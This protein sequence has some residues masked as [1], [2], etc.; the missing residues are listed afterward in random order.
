MA[1]PDGPDQR[2]CD[3]DALLS[4]QTLY[5]CPRIR[6]GHRCRR[7]GYSDRGR[8]SGGCSQRSPCRQ[9]K[10]QREHQFRQEGC[11]CGD[12]APR[13]LCRR[14]TRQ[15][16]HCLQQSHRRDPF[17]T[18]RGSRRVRLLHHQAGRRIRHG[19]IQGDGELRT[20]GILLLAS[21]EGMRNR[22]G[23]VLADRRE[24]EGPFPDK[25]VR[26]D[27]RC[28]GAHADTLRH[29]ALRLPASQGLLL[30]TGV[31]CDARPAAYLQG[32]TGDVPQNGVQCRGAQPGRPHE[33]HLVPDGQR[34]EM[35]PVSGLRHGLRLQSRRPV[36]LGPPDVD[37]RQ[38]QRHHQR[39]PARMRSQEQYQEC[40]TDYRR[41]L[42][43][44]IRM[45]GDRPGV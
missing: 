44:S 10:L 42:P 41:G 15:G 27:K 31:R 28:K 9:I 19:R 1:G 14:A 45:A 12:S 38:I 4:G 6:A 39:R 13:H 25:E 34:R 16:N 23:R 11:H 22:H 43:G 7:Y 36:D 26:P 30:R 32:S 24:R 29:R 3:R 33:E 35:A 37:K 2:Q 8:F 17:G 20:S 40:R 18:G 21:C 5:G